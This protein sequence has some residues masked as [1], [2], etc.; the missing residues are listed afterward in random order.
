MSFF[1]HDSFNP[2]DER[3][4]D[5]PIDQ[6]TK[7]IDEAA[8]EQLPQLPESLT[9][10]IEPVSPSTPT[11]GS[12][13]Q[14]QQRPTPN[15]FQAR[16]DAFT[17]RYQN[18]GQLTAQPNEAQE[19]AELRDKL[20]NADNIMKAILADPALNKPSDSFTSQHIAAIKKY[21]QG[22]MYYCELLKDDLI[23]SKNMPPTV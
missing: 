12:T 20:I 19:A 16:M 15:P 7:T 4:Y 5:Q 6:L 17:K 11:G 9:E 2:H 14:A 18:S 10:S 8:P 23:K 21:L 1:N 3:L 13:S 22:T